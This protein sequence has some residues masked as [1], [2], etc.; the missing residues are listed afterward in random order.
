MIKRA[1][2]ATKCRIASEVYHEGIEIILAPGS[3]SVFF[4]NRM[5]AR[6]DTAFEVGK[7]VV[8]RNPRSSRGRDCCQSIMLGQVWLRAAGFGVTED[9]VV[10]HP[11]DLGRRCCRVNMLGYG[12]VRI[13][14]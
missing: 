12:R 10:I 8:D 3:V 13:A 4:Q 7:D 11:S 1:G 2:T 9:G 5:V 6:D 14:S